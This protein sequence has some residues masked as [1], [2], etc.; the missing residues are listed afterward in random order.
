MICPVCGDRWAPFRYDHWRWG[1]TEKG[2]PV[3][4][5]RVSNAKELWQKDFD[6]DYRVACLDC[7]L[8]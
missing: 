1:D 3:H 6:T 7:R 4:V 8:T 5:P 2:E